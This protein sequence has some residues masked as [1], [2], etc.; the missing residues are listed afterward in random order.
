MTVS[1]DRDGC[2]SCGMCAEVCPDIFFMADDGLADV[3]SETVPSGQETG[4]KNAAEVC[5][6]EVIHAE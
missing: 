4:A 6:V 1:I 3:K 5:P 2:I